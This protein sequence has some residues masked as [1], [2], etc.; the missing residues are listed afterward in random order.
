LF[1]NSTTATQTDVSLVGAGSPFTLD[2]WSGS[3]ERVA[4]FSRSAGRVTVPVK[5][6]PSAST[7]IAVS[8]SGLDGSATTPAV[9]VQS[10]TADVV[11]YQQSNVVVRAASAGTYETALSNGETASTRIDHVPATQSLGHWNLQVESW[12]PPPSGMDTL[13]TQLPAVTVDAGA[14]G[15]LP[16]W[17]ALG[18]ANESGVGTYTTTIELPQPW[19]GGFG[20]YLELGAV[21]DTFTVKVNG[22]ALPMPDQMDSSRIDVGPY[23]KQGT[24]TIQVRESTTLRNS[25]ISKQPNQAGGTTTEHQVYG[26]IGPVHLVPYG[27][28]P[29]YSETNTDGTVGGNVP[30]T[31]SLSLG[32]PATFGAFAPGLGKDYFA[33][34]TANITSTAGDALL[35]VSDP[36]TTATGHLVNGSFS[37]SQPLQARARN[38]SNSGTAYNDVGARLNLLTWS[39][40]V[41]NDAVALEFKQSIGANDALRTGSYSKTL[42][43]TLSTTSP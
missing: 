34:T 43:Y 12:G 9:A 22:T 21:F 23:L 41:S 42:T 39:G 6:A 13:K 14:D 25:I 5:L 33:S 38:A 32:A 40:P 11:R 37:L 4:R 7:I 1:N 3:I 16:S 19:T 31:L 28:A 26:M 36:S 15:K 24:N 17:T 10:T 29:A 20:A 27:Q 35:S 30:A 2:A 18:L 8:R